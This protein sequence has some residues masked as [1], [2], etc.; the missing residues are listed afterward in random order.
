[1]K[2]SKFHTKNDKLGYGP[3]TTWKIKMLGIII[4]TNPYEI[5]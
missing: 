2:K 4:I 3:K 1:M 5:K